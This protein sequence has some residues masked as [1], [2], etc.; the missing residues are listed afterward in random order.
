MDHRLECDERYGENK[1][2]KG[3]RSDGVDIFERMTRG[4]PLEM[5]T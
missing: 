5:I 4:S 3:N 1:V 2:E